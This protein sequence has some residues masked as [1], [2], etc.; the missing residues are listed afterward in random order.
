M[1]S[2]TT[3]HQRS[4]NP[5]TLECIAEYAFYSEAQIEERVQACFEAQRVWR[6]TEIELRA[7]YFQRLAHILRAH[8]EEAALLM[9][10]EMGKPL[11]QGRAEMLKCA[12][13]CEYMAHEAIQVLAPMG[14]ETEYQS[15]RIHFQALG[16]LFAIMPWNFPFWQV[17]RAAVPAMMA[18]N[19]VILKHSPEVGGCALMIQRLFE[20]AGMNSG[21][22]VT[23]LA[24]VEQAARVIQHPSVSAVTFTGSTRG[25]RAV[26]ALA[27][28]ALKKSVLELGGSD[29]YCVLDDCDV[30]AAARICATSRLINAGQSCV[31]AKRFIVM[32]SVAKQF[33][34]AFVAEM[35]KAIVGNPLDASTTVGPMARL[36][37]RDALVDQVTRS[38]Q[39]GARVLL[40]GGK[41]KA[42]ELQAA[43]YYP[44]VISGVQP[45]MP[46][47]DEELFGPAAAIIHARNEEELIELAN[48]SS[49]GLASAVFSSDTVRAE[50]VALSLDAGCCFV[51]DFVKSDPRFPFGGVKDSG[52]GRELSAF[53][54]REFVNVKPILV[55]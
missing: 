40:E 10:A 49:Y 11:A 34:E 6:S 30:E 45:G 13:C 21:E 48:R 41:G 35:Q 28:H 9:A 12:Q 4:I 38:V 44:S 31:S 17:I 53:G 18:G 1:S 19:T 5:A 16:L 46:A 20:E 2:T 15:S 32:S 54:I 3:L 43:Y 23:I 22:F 14:V 42:E 37:L 36:D 50:R 7:I 52:W 51:N 27:G 25:G 8:V 24:S 47:F 39:A 29:A 55:A 33:E 26:A